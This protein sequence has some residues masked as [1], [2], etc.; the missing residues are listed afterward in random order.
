[1]AFDL[2]TIVIN[3]AD[4]QGCAVV[5]GEGFEFVMTLGTGTGTAL[6]NAG[7]LLP[8][9]ELGHAPLRKNETVDVLYEAGGQRLVASALPVE[10][11]A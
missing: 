2:P 11:D 10:D 9:L 4:M 7:R 6:F 5:R 8:H 3:D 1:M